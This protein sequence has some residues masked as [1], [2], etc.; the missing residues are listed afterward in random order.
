MTGLVNVIAW[1]ENRDE[2]LNLAIQALAATEVSGVETNVALLEKALRH[3][4]FT[5]GRHS[6]NLIEGIA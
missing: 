3:P 6:T 1:G 2:A 5:A 4:D